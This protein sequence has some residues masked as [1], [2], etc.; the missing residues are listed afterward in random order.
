MKIRCPHCEAQYNVRDELRG[1]QARCSRCQKEMRLEPAGSASEVLALDPWADVHEPAEKPKPANAKPATAQP[2]SGKSSKPKPAKTKA[3]T[4]SDEYGDVEPVRLLAASRPRKKQDSDSENTEIETVEQP[5]R[6]RRIRR[7]TWGMLA[8]VASESFWLSALMHFPYL[9]G[10]LAVVGALLGFLAGL[11]HSTAVAGML[12]QMVGYPTAMMVFFSLCY[13]ASCFLKIVIGTSDSSGDIHEWPESNFGEWVFELVF[14]GYMV[15]VSIMFGAAIA[16]VRQAAFEDESSAQT[17]WQ[18]VGHERETDKISFF[19]KLFGAQQPIE[20][21]VESDRPM[22]QPGPGWQTTF[23]AFILIFPLVMLS[24]LDPQ[25]PFLIPW[26]PQVLFSLVKNIPAWL[27][28][29]I[30]SGVILT[31]AALIVVLGAAYAPFWTFT[32]CSPLAAAALLI[33][34]RLLGRLSWLIART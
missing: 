18:L 5:K 6:K 26:S 16:K 22:L 28:V 12:F 1:R 17:Y 25:S 8:G 27:V 19:P 7:T 20:T 30:I 4:T 33:Y 15:I 23:V 10:A 3:R 2:S 11:V 29:L 31:S 32:L 9:V 14:L 13:P 21:E 24:C 34:A